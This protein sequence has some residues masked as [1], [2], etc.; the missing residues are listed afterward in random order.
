[1]YVG[2]KVVLT[3]LA[4]NSA[5]HVELVANAWQ[6]TGA[7]IHQLQPEQH[8]AVFAAVSHLP[9][10]LSFAMV[11]EV[12]RK[13][14]ADLLLQYAASGFR[15]FTRLASSSPEMW[16]DISL[17]NRQAILI[18]LDAYIA[19]LA[20]FRKQLEAQDG[21]AMQAMFTNAQQ[22]REAWLLR[23]EAAK[24]QTKQNDDA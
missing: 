18:E 17:T 6:R 21:A 8:D 19:Q 7:D 2:K 4:E 3:P 5:A 12:V 22:A 20:R 9:H 11:D 13:P 15:D 1:L 23:M 16:R 10:L 14:N 24:P